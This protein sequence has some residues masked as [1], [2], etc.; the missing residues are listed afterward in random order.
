MYWLELKNAT[1]RMFVCLQ[2]LNASRWIDFRWYRDRWPWRQLLAFFK[3]ILTR[4]RPLAK[5]IKHDEFEIKILYSKINYKF[6]L[7]FRF[8]EISLKVIKTKDF[9]P[10]WHFVEPLAANLASQIHFIQTSKAI[11]IFIANLLQTV[12]Y[13]TKLKQNIKVSKLRKIFGFQQ[14]AILRHFVD[15]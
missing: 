5:A 14:H 8:Y 15:N 11:T 13:I 2:R 1:M 4:A 6:S 3:S 7:L 12:K 10:I 9:N